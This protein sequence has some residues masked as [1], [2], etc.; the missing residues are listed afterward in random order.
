[1]YEKPCLI[2]TVASRYSFA[3]LKRL[4]GSTKHT[5]R[6]SCTPF[7]IFFISPTKH[8]SDFLRLLD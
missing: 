4:G 3:I 7:P 6:E 2:P 5:I 1:M 8:G